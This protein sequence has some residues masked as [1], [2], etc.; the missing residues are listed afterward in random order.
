M[1]ENLITFIDNRKGDGGKWREGK[2]KRSS[3]GEKH[4]SS[5]LGKQNMYITEPSGKPFLLT[6][7]SLQGVPEPL[8]LA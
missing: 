6:C 2:K 7:D 5:P 8:L 3:E 1:V 4:P